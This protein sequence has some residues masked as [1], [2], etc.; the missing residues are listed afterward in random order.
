M[1]DFKRLSAILLLALFTISC[2]LPDL[3]TLLPAPNAVLAGEQAAPPISSDEQATPAYVLITSAPD[4]TATPTPFQPIPPTAILTPTAIPTLTPFPTSTLE[5]ALV[6]PDMPA[7][8][9]PELDKQ[10][11]ILLLGSDKRPGDSGFRTDTIIL[12]VLNPQQGTASLLSFP[13]DL[14]VHIPGRGQDRINT[15][16]YSGGFKTLA[17]TMEYNFGVRPQHYV[18]INFRSFKQMIDSVG[19][20]TVKVSTPVTDKYPGKGWIT[21]PKGTVKMNADIALWYARSRKTSNDFARNRR[22]QEVLLALFEKFI[23]M[24]ALKRVPE[25]YK[26][27][28]KSISTDLTLTDGLSMLPLAIQLTD[29]SRIKRYYISPTHVWDHITP[30]GAM[31]LL[32]REA[33]IRKLVKQAVTGK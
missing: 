26:I 2:A 31:V 30:G 27:Y 29:T 20:L 16:F 23:S 3:A 15:A 24:D 5:P 10:V 32:P 14:Y 12:L 7:E 25:F 22:Q 4:S 33:E 18:L 6:M 9:I 11:T 28:K 13:R 21:I 1:P 8:A 19:G 17:A